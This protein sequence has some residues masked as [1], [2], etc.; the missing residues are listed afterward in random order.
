MVAERQWVETN[1]S[2]F[3]IFPTDI[4]LSPPHGTTLTAFADVW[5]SNT[6]VVGCYMGWFPPT[7]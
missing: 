1:Q 2:N 3:R 7:R 5:M 4:R 6:D